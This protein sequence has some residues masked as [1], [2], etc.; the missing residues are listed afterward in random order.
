MAGPEKQSGKLILFIIGTAI[1]GA[2]FSGYLFINHFQEISGDSILFQLCSIS[3]SFDCSTVNKSHYSVFMGFP[4]AGYGLF[5]YLFILMFLPLYHVINHEKFS[6]FLEGLFLITS[7]FSVLTI[8]PLALISITKLKTYCLF[9]MII[10]LCNIVLF[11]LFAA[12]VRRKENTTFIRA[13]WNVLVSFFGFL[14]RFYMA[15]AHVFILVSVSTSLFAAILFGGEYLSIKRDLER[16]SSNLEE[17]DKLISEFYSR[18]VLNSSVKGVPVFHGKSDSAVTIVEY[19][20]FNCPAC[21]KGLKTMEELTKQYPGKLAVYLKNFPLD[22]TCN[23]VAIKD[24]GGLSCTSALISIALREKKGY[25][26]Y[27]DQIMKSDQPLSFELVEKA[28]ADVGVKPEDLGNMFKDGNAKEILNQEIKE[29]IALEIK[30]TPSFLI[31]G[32][33]ISGL[34]PFYILNRLIQVELDASLREKFR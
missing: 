22:S 7:F 10:W 30:S 28:L 18:P 25:H 21:K 4:I 2:I 26:H 33:L 20:D 17:L 16:A 5:Y 11:L 32:R 27:V 34:P 31:N 29:G 13:F 9:C 12:L 3:D 8:L 15:P 1:I 6:L 19:S 24:K 23:P 14:K